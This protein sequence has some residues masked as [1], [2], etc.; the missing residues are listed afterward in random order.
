LDKTYLHSSY[1]PEREAKKIVGTALGERRPTLVILG[2]ACLDY[3]TIEVRARFPGAMILS[4]QYSELFRGKELTKAGAIRYPADPSS[5]ESFLDTFIDEDAISGIA[6][7]EWPAAAKAFPE[8]ARATAKTLR[9]VLDRLSASAATIKNSGKQW[10]RNAARSFLLVE[11]LA[12]PPAEKTCPTTPIV[13]AAAGPSLDEALEVLLPF[14]EEIHLIAVSSALSCCLA[15]GFKP[16]LVVATDGGYW[17]RSHLYPFAREDGEKFQAEER[18]IHARSSLSASQSAPFSTL[19]S[20]LSALPSA[21]L[22]SRIA[23][24]P[25]DQKAFPESELTCFLGSSIAIPSGGTVVHTALRLAT[26]WTQGPIVLAGLDLAARGIRAHASAH[27]FESMLLSTAGRLS[28]FESLAYSR[29]IPLA[30]EKIPN[31]SWRSSR[32]LSSYASA[33]PNYFAD[34]TERIFRLFPS[35]VELPGFLKI[36]KAALGKLFE[37]RVRTKFDLAIRQAPPIEQRKRYLLEQIILWRRNANELLVAI[38]TGGAALAILRQAAD[39]PRSLELFRAVDYP[40][41]AATRRAILLGGDPRP[42]A[43]SLRRN[44]EEFLEDLEGRLLS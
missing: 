12:L 28:P 38:E 3:L 18:G 7:I 25:I 42:A 21:A 5:I 31:S 16:D 19:A 40:D 4:L 13:V 36:E 11:S 41:W 17:S 34:A 37:R 43:R 2:G 15:R 24:L 44:T 30:P 29:E 22:S 9:R 27:A 33:L 14:Q 32:S 26:A 23:L 35:P 1:D 10:I 39:K 20:P 6:F 8:E